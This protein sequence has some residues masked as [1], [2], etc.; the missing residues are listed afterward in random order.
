M[1][2]KIRLKRDGLLDRILNLPVSY[3]KFNFEIKSSNEKFKEKT[4][5]GYFRCH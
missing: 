3:E 2:S 1:F 5:L 4:C